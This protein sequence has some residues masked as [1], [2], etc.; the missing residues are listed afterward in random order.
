MG[1]ICA[2]Q[3]GSNES[4]KNSLHFWSCSKNMTFFLF[5]L[6]C[7]LAVC[8]ILPWLEVALFV[9]AQEKKKDKA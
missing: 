4:Q 7:D 1:I 2:L 5:N 8:E 6:G 3:S 9:M